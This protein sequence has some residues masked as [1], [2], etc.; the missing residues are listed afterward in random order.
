[1][2]SCFSLSDLTFELGAIF[3]KIEKEPFFETCVV[4]MVIRPSIEVLAEECFLR[5]RCLS[6][7]RFESELKLG[8]IERATFGET[9]SVYLKSDATMLTKNIERY[10]MYRVKL[11]IYS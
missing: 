11:Y 5:C 4:E 2:V 10:L 9:G 1:M 6:P 3:P 7:V 8:R